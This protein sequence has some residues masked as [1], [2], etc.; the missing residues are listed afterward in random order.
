MADNFVSYDRDTLF[1]MPPSVQEW[2][3][4]K[5]LA[6]FVVDIVA[7]LDLRVLRDSYAGR[8]SAAYHPEM[9]VALLFY[10][11]ATGVRSSYKIAAATYDSVAFRYIAANK[12]PDHDTIAAFRR[13]FLPNLDVIFNEI[14]R[15]AKELKCLEIGRVSLDGT[16]INAS[17]SKHRALSLQGADRIE[18]QLRRE[19]KRM[20]ELA[21][22]ADQA[23]EAAGRSEFEL[24]AEL[25]RREDRL[26]AIAEAKARIKAREA[27]R[28]TQ[29]QADRD[30]ALADRERIEASTGKKMKSRPPKRPKKGIRPEAQ[31]NLTDAESRIMPSHEGFIQG[32]NAQ[33]AV[34]TASMLIVAADLSQRPTDR[35]L[36]KPMLRKLS[37]LPLGTIREVIADAG[38]F[39]ELNVELCNESGITPYIVP[40]RNRHY[41][42][43]RHWKIAKAPGPR[44]SSLTKMLHRLRTPAGR[45]I[46]A[47]RKHTVEPVF[48]ILKRALGFRQFSL[49]GFRKARG[50]YLLACSA[51]NIKRLHTM[52]T[53]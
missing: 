19:V 45:A 11:Y 5:H 23:D 16:K 27:E 39:S 17:A 12:H 3:P 14:L 48:G 24:P 51:W 32:Y 40:K 42:G 8:G 49:R 46:Y 25:A 52:V 44:A 10:G 34:D 38:Y 9:L 50:E 13:R 41:W 53:A 29:E 26:K 15:L 22:E 7:Q 6:R 43:L 1:L 18:A 20:L 36:L 2:L 21:E 47:L 28:Q 4:E 35:R 33:A 31:L 30:E 37:T